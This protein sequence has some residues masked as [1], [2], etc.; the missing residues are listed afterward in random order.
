[1]IFQGNKKA[2]NGKKDIKKIKRKRKSVTFNKMSNKNLEKAV[3]MVTCS[4]MKLPSIVISKSNTT[5]ML[6][7][8]MTTNKEKNM[9]KFIRE[10]E[11]NNR[12]QFFD[13]YREKPRNK[14]M[15]CISEKCI[16]PDKM[17]F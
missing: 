9:K 16:K 15:L 7:F 2:P 4:K 17:K 11:F 14:L 13:V 12:K 10:K 5:K 1:M 8:F 6:N 3:S